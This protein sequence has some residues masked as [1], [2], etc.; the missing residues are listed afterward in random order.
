VTTTRIHELAAEFGIPSEQLIGM[1]KEQDIFVRSHL[2]PLK[3]EQVALMRA[4]WEREKRKLKDAPAPAKR[5]RTAR[6]VEPVAPAPEPRPLR[7]RRT[8]A[9]VAA[10]EAEAQA[11]AA[12]EAERELKAREALEAARAE[13]VEEK[14]SLEERAAAL[15]KDLPAAEETA[16]QAASAAAFAPPPAATFTGAVSSPAP[17]PVIPIP[18]RPKPVASATPGGPVPPR[19]LASAAPGALPVEERRREKGKKRKKGKKSLVD[20]EAVAQ[21]I[22]RTLASLKGPVARKGAHRR[23]E[24]PTFRDLEEQKRRDEKEREKTLVRVTEFITVSELAN[25]LKVPAK[26]IVSF[27]FKELG[28]MVTINQRLDF[29]MIELIA[30]AFGFQAMREE[31]YALA[32]PEQAKEAADDLQP[33]PPVVT[34]MG[35]VD[36][37]KTSLLDYVRKTNVVAGEAGGITQHIGAYQ[38]TLKEGRSITFLDTPGHEAFTAMRARGAQVT[39]IVVLVVAADDAIMPQTIEAISHAKNAGVPLVV[40]INKIDLP[41]ANV[42]KVKQDLLTHGVVLEEFGGTTLATAISAKTGKSVQ[43]LL[44][45][46]LLQAELLDLKANPDRHALGTVLEATLDPGKGPLA[47]VLVQNGTLRVADDFISGQYYGRV[48]ALYDERG[49]PVNEAG[50]STPVQ[51]LGFEGVPEA[52]DTFTVMADAA[53]ARD[54]AQKRQRL[55]REAQHRRTSRVKTLEDFMAERAAGGAAALTII[56][57]ADQGGPAEALADALSQLSTPEVKVEIVHRGVGAITDSDVLLA[58]ASNA[59]I[60]GF[61]V[62]PDSNARASAER[63]KVEIRTYR[64]I[65]EAVEDV[66]AAMEGLLA[67]EKKEVVLGEAEVRQTFKIAKVGTI[68]GCFVRSGVIPRTARVRVIRDGVE[69]YEGTI[70]SLKRF[71]DDVREVREGFECGIGIENFNDVKVGDLIEAYRIEEVAR[72]LDVGSAAKSG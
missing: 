70:A 64:I 5:R 12:V 33:R 62:R 19:P 48:R 45:Q 16:A 27:A 13:D 49:Q 55:E 2:T 26:E 59:I 14:P 47:T 38:V 11:E 53:A 9:E 56:I 25:I 20:Q 31:E 42:Q 22:S 29:D 10:A 3:P 37:G 54:I 58:K 24:G 67:P 18:V 21:N 65:Y 72:S 50:P 43:E 32:E 44:D 57:K 40:A 68:A 41:T 69:V 46:I 51:V 17:R 30:S 8:A 1:L 71:K 39:D 6:V 28:Q 60:I 23:E 34:V 63:E 4:R 35:H 36:H 7:R 52:G 61:H 15:F 66:R